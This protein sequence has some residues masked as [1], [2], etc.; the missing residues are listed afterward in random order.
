MDQAKFSL[1]RI[2]ITPGA[3]DA[4]GTTGQDPGPF[5]LR[6]AAGDWGDLDPEDIQTND[7]AIIHEGDADRQQRVLSSY[8]T[9]AGAKLWIITEWDRS[10]TTILLPDEY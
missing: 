8:R 6:H 4:L 10:V 7:Q 2:V 9:S 5:L 1:G 3:I